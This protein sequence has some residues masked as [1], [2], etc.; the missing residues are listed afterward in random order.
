MGF[1]LKLVLRGD[2]MRLR[3]LG[4]ILTLLLVTSPSIASDGARQ[5]PPQAMAEPCHGQFLSRFKGPAYFSPAWYEF[6]DKFVRQRTT[7]LHEIRDEFATLVHDPSVTLW[8]V[9]LLLYRLFE[10]SPYQGGEPVSL[11]RVIEASDRYKVSLVNQI[12][13]FRDQ[14]FD[15]LLKQRM[16]GPGTAGLRA[17]TEINVYSPFVYGL[18]KGLKGEFRMVELVP[19]TRLAVGSTRRGADGS[20]EFTGGATFSPSDLLALVVN[21]KLNPGPGDAAEVA[22]LIDQLKMRLGLMPGVAIL[23]LAEFR[24]PSNF[25]LKV[26]NGGVKA[27][28]HIPSTP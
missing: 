15:H 6:A 17:R 12:Q 24:A 21:L 7:T 13:A 18:G 16:S 1:F 9:N 19:L 25:K 4:F 23:E 10:L 28:E 11:Y 5:L 3:G 20:L 27:A 8:Q 22:R 26:I 14:V 2:F